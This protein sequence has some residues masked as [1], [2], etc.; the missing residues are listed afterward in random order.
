MLSKTI[1]S[2]PRLLKEKRVVRSASSVSSVWFL[3]SRNTEMDSSPTREYHALDLV[4]TRYNFTINTI[5]A[6]LKIRFGRA[7][8]KNFISKSNFSEEFY[9]ITKTICK[10]R[11]FAENC[12][13][14]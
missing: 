7:A 4:E 10:I 9:K 13:V 6:Y 1:F 14:V 3:N 5:E 8:V 2:P 11:F 12:L